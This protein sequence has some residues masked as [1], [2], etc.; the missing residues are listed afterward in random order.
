MLV[1]I[2]LPEFFTTETRGARRL[3]ITLA[4]DTA[5]TTGLASGPPCQAVNLAFTRC[6]SCL[7]GES[8]KLEKPT[9]EDYNTLDKGCQVFGMR[10]SRTPKGHEMIVLL[11]RAY[12]TSV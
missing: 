5:P 11:P 6:L 10:I 7:G 2:T 3:P 1:R 4:S 8:P 12:E 9:S